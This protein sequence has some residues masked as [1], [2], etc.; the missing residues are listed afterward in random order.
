[1]DFG[2]SAFGV[3]AS[4]GQVK[5]PFKM[6]GPEVAKIEPENP[7]NDDKPAARRVQENNGGTLG[8]NLGK[9]SPDCDGAKGTVNDV[10]RPPKRRKADPKNEKLKAKVKTDGKTY[11]VKV[12]AHHL[13]PGNA[14]LKNAKTLQKFMTKGKKV[15]SVLG[16]KFT[17]KEHIGYNINGAHNG[18]WLPGNYA[19]RKGSSPKK[20][21]SWSGLTADPAWEDWCYE[22]MIACTGVAGGQFHDSHPKYSENV[23]KVLNTVADKLLDHIDN[24]TECAGKSGKQVYPPYFLKNWLYAFSGSLRTKCKVKPPKIL[25]PWCTSDAFSAQMARKG[26]AKNA[27]GFTG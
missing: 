22:Y 6:T 19:I 17:I 4:I 25:F 26:A 8:D 15:T 12:A 24:C 10:K 16:N 7:P 27:P 3:V 23:L 18:V 13:I 21:T 14:S 2:E 5:C 20:K 1:M 9:V 11:P